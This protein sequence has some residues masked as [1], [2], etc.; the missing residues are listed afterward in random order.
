MNRHPSIRLRLI[1]GSTLL[2]ALV[3]SVGTL[4]LY[5]TVRSSLLRQIDSRLLQE[6]SLLS[7]S[8]ELV[9]SGIMHKWRQS[10]PE[11]EKLVIRGW[12]QFWEKDGKTTRSPDLGNLDLP[13]FHGRPME[14][15]TRNVELS[16][17]TAV[18]AT[19]LLHYPR[20]SG[21][22]IQQRRQRGEEAMKLEDY[23]MV[24]VSAI[25]L[26]PMEKEMARIRN[27][28]LIFSAIAIAAIWMSISAITK[29]CL[30]PIRD[31]TATLA[32]R[33]A[34]AAGALDEIPASFPGELVPLAQ[35]FN[36]NLQLVEA[37]HL[38]EK[39]FAFSAAHELRTPIAGVQA[40]LEQVLFRPREPEDLRRRLE[41][42]LQLTERTGLTVA[43]LMRLA[44]IRGNLERPE[45][46]S[47]NGGEVLRDIFSSE[48]L[49]HPGKFDTSNTVAESV[50]VETD[51]NLFRILAGN[52]I[53]NAFRH[54]PPGGIIQLSAEGNHPGFSFTVTNSRGAFAVE[55][56]ERIFRPFEKG[57]ATSVD[58]P[59]AGLGLTL[60]AE[61]ASRLEGQ[62]TVSLDDPGSI[63]FRFGLP[64]KENE[65]QSH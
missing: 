58:S 35:A 37:A 2:A 5:K 9:P 21:I 4:I 53:Q 13:Y 47:F 54:T 27:Y 41:S 57:S 52:L 25:P 61:I 18:R 51:E 16:D 49:N 22:L 31:T 11:T 33:S 8:V 24:L 6:V 63:S 20:P 39:E 44:R 48:L 17:G 43:A 46:A 59:G 7:K 30:K 23:P 3:L 1:L 10:T 45:V 65:K 19:A 29:W 60:A 40:I 38:H 62:L 12:F 15:V 42:A 26:A 55:D 14:L 50:W 34:Q 64:Q 56:A 32:G 36:H 28:L